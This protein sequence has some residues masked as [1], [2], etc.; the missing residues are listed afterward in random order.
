MQYINSDNEYADDEYVLADS[1]A[2]AADG[3]Y[4]EKDISVPGMVVTANVRKMANYFLERLRINKN[5]SLTM[6]S[7]GMALEPEDLVTLTHSRPGW[8]EKLLRVTQPSISQNGEVGLTLEEEDDAMYDDIYNL[9]THNWYDTNLPRPSDA[10]AS[11]INVSNTEEVYNYRGRSFTRW[12]IDFDKP[13][14]ANYP[15]WDYAEIYIKIG[16]TGD[17]K[18]QT[19]A[20][21]DYVLDPVEEGQE[22]FCCIVSVSIWGTKQAFADGF[23]I[24][25]TIA[26]KITIPDDLTGMTALAHGDNV[27]IFA[28]EL[29]DPDIAG[30]EVRLGSA[31]AGGIFIGFNETPNIRL[32]G[33]RPAT[34]TFWMAAKDNA[35]NYSSTPASAQC[36][37]YYPSGYADIAT[38]AWDYDG[39]GTH[40]NT[41]HVIYDGGDVLKCSHTSGVLTGTWTSPE[42]D[43][44]SVI[45]TRIW[46]DFI[47]AFV[48]S[49][50]TWTASLGTGRTWTEALGTGT[51]WYEVLA[52][53]Y[54]G[55][56]EA[57]M[58][59]GNS[60]GS[61]TN[62]ASKMEIL[63]AE[64]SARY[65]QFEITIT[66]PDVGSNLYLKELNLKAAYWS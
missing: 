42:Y 21:T 40:D 8:D 57:T 48:S 26:G 34:H 10:V 60:S 46:G 53:A 32:V 44:G 5:A 7:R 18:F 14:A 24:S 37:V 27:T 52:P 41:E 16:A 23:L 66:D 39:I 50:G 54:A 1:V 19:K 30:Y 63:S 9:E 58:K 29:T 43:L 51:R 56:V 12:K 22:Y 36:I 55:V 3:D 59:W 65:V 64:I 6:G 20:I 28:N 47:T 35:G 13:L 61:L 45:T 17:W 15:F 25:R 2:I 38:W 4:R 31:W 33:V 62:S 11:V 49:S